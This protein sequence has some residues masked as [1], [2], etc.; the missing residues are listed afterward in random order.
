[1][2][3]S[4]RS[5]T[6]LP[7]SGTDPDRK[8]QQHGAHSRDRAAANREEITGQRAPGPDRGKGHRS[9]RHGAG[10]CHRHGA[11]Q[12]EAAAPGA[13]E[14]PGPARRDP[15]SAPHG[16]LPPCRPSARPPAPHT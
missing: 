8:H 1:M 9:R 14:E 5:A 2:I 15:L 11:A 6:A 13:A 7:P 12:A 16:R 10:C 4:S 3:Q